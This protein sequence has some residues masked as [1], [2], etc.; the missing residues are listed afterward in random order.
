MHAASLII[1][2]RPTHIPQDN[3]SSGKYGPRGAMRFEC[4]STDPA[5]RG[6]QYARALLEPVKQAVPSLGYAD[7]WQLAAVVSVEVMGGPKVPFRKP[8][9]TPTTE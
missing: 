7:L 6:L 1:S 2:Q 5:N 3:A 8:L 4:E 9:P